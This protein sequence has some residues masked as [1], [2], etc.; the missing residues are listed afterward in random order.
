MG[1][2]SEISGLQRNPQCELM[3]RST[4][5]FGTQWWQ[6][7]RRKEVRAGLRFQA[8]LVFSQRG[9]G[10]ETH[11]LSPREGGRMEPDWEMSGQKRCK[12]RKDE[13]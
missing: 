8:T 10:A 9:D 12:T 4:C 2:G 7:S 3:S 13:A 5:V 1:L 11:Q 6:V